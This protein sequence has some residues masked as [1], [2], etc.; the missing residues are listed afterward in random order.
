M[1][2]YPVFLID[3]GMLVAFFN[4]GDEH[5]SQVYP[6]IKDSTAVMITTVACITETMYLLPR[7]W[8]V[9]NDLFLMVAQGIIECEHLQSQDFTRIAEL[10]LFRLSLL[11]QPC[12]YLYW[13]VLYFT[14]LQ[15]IPG[16]PHAVFPGNAER[17]VYTSRK[18]FINNRKKPPISLMSAK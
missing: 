15:L 17:G 16:Y 5:H 3:T 11:S 12:I 9:Q 4:K 10:L 7:Y 1:N 2:H 8:K 13:T 6:F 14:F 18:C